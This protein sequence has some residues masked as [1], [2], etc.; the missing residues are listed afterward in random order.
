MTRLLPRGGRGEC[1]PPA[2]SALPFGGVPM[3]P[4]GALGP[5]ALPSLRIHAAV[6]KSASA[7]RSIDSIHIAGASSKVNPMVFE[8]P[9]PP[10]LSDR[11]DAPDP[12]KSDGV[13]SRIPEPPASS[14]HASSSDA[15]ASG[16]ARASAIA[17][18]SGAPINRDGV[19]SRFPE[20]PASSPHASNSD[21]IASGL[22]GASRARRWRLRATAAALELSE[23]PPIPASPARV[24]GVAAGATPA[25]ASMR[26]PDVLA[27]ESTSPPRLPRWPSA[28]PTPAPARN[29]VRTRPRLSMWSGPSTSGPSGSTGPAPRRSAE[30]GG[31]GL[32]CRVLRKRKRTKRAPSGRGAWSELE[33]PCWELAASPVLGMAPA[34]G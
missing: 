32:A 1:E 3:R 13:R 7:G 33:A 15:I 26:C 31:G 2:P 10:P 19:R 21:A 8:S 34:L 5:A 6:L 30:A 23:L 25:W 18:P 27:D 12:V 11:G 4:P 17:G 9:P 16:L 20:P 29:T 22:T 24:W 14:S 28:G